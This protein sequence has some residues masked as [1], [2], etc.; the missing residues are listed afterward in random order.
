MR[1][2]IVMKR[3]NKKGM[4]KIPCKYQLMKKSAWC[5]KAGNTMKKMIPF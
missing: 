2:N 5:E 3:K 4:T 1:K